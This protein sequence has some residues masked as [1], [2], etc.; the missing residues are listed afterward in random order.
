MDAWKAAHP[1]GKMTDAEK[2]AFKDELKGW[3]AAVQRAVDEAKRRHAK[4]TQSSDAKGPVDV[5][6]L[7][8]PRKG[9]RATEE[10]PK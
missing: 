7:R 5:V 2:Q 1:D 6:L 4:T 10:D 3:M 9:P 8:N